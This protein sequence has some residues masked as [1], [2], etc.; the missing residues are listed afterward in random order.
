M[1]GNLYKYIFYNIFEDLDFKIKRCEYRNTFEW[2]LGV[3]FLNLLSLLSF[4]FMV[5]RI[6]FIVAFIECLIGSLKEDFKR[7]N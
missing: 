1:I 4:E 6:M 2:L 3:M 5:L 7:E